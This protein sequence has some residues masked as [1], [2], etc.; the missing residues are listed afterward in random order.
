MTPHLERRPMENEKLIEE[1]M[2]WRVSAA[3]DSGIPHWVSLNKGNRNLPFA[4][5]HEDEA[6]MI[7]QLA[8]ALAAATEREARMREACEQG[9]IRAENFLKGMRFAPEERTAV[10]LMVDSMIQA[11]QFDFAAALSPAKPTEE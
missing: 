10:T 6:E 5:I 4:F 1:A 2:A 7:V 3:N 8:T 11:L 9:R